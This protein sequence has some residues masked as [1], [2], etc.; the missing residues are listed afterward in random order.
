M[1]DGT[2]EFLGRVDTQVKLRGFRVEPGEVEE[3]LRSHPQVRDAVVVTW[4]EGAGRRLAAYV[5]VAGPA[6]SADE[7]QSLLRSQLPEYMVPSAVITLERLPLTASGK[8]DRKALPEPQ[9]LHVEQAYAAPATPT[10]EALSEVWA[11]VLGLPRVGVHDDFF[12]LGGHSL[13]ATQVV[14]RV[15]RVFGVELPLR[16]LFEQPTVRGLARV[17][18]QGRSAPA[19]PPIVATGEGEAP[20]SFAQ[21]RL[22]F[23]EQLQPGTAAY[24]IP[25]A[26]RLSGALDRSALERALFRIVERHE[27]LRTRYLAGDRDV[28]QRVSPTSFSL[29]VIDL[30]GRAESE[31]EELWRARAEALAAAPFDLS[32]DLPLRGELLAL[33]PREHVLFVCGHHI[34]WDGWSLGVFFRELSALYGAYAGGAPDPLPEL[35][36]QYGDY[37][38]W[39]R[40]SLTGEALESQLRYWSER[41]AGTTGVLALPTDRPRPAVKGYRGA[42]LGVEVPGAVRDALA[43]LARREGA[44][45]YMVL[46]AV[47]QALLGRWSRQSDV[48]VG[49]PSRAAGARRRA[50]VST[51]CW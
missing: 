24:N 43:A 19:A 49:T 34:A 25:Q 1:P 15:R 20:L 4:G 5:V 32:N 14:S 41:L 46:L 48:L 37:A 3:A 11:S 12:A 38:R 39:Q 6:P 17:M 26:W 7:L 9:A 22:W 40:A 36:V 2:L 30:S 50:S 45:L 8:V 18:A 31:R 28:V 13:L 29:P 42:H 23:L 35:A 10:E 16:S 47:L 21:Q 27:V 33:S 51:T 44:T